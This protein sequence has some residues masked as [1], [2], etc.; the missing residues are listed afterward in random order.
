MK[1]IYAIELGVIAVVFAVLGI[2]VLA[3]VILI[4]D[5]KRNIFPWITL[6]GGF[7]VIGDLIWALASTKRR[8]RVSLLDKFLLLPSAIAL[9]ICDLFAIISGN[10]PDTFYQYYIGTVFCY[11]A[12][13]YITENIYHWFF[14]IPGL[15]EEEKKPEGD[16]Q[17]Q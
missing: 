14:P 16:S 9:I 10:M 3:N 15:F 4:N 2:L 17:I 5:W 6:F 13:V 8:A 7:L 11:L 1:L 12:C